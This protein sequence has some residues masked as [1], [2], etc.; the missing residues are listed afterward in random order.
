[1]YPIH[2]VDIANRMKGFPGRF[3]LIKPVFELKETRQAGQMELPQDLNGIYSIDTKLNSL[4]YS[5]ASYL[6]I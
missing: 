6:G 1:M 5:L 2:C 3:C 4:L